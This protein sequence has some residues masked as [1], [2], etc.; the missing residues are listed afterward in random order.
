MAVDD[1]EAARANPG[2]DMHVLPAV[3]EA[4]EKRVSRGLWK[5]LARVAGKIPFA[6]DAAAAYF[7]AV[8]T[9]TPI[10]VRGAL[11]AAL[12]Y[13]II[14]IDMIPDFLAG[15]GYTDDA[16]V[17]AMALALVS[18][19]VKPGHRDAARRALD[20]NIKPSPSPS[21]PPEH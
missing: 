6:E 3:V 5:K 9:E 14:P 18:G 21:P 19:Y 13:F 8:D 2:L 4:N 11:L 16:S 15:L 1:N 7:C 12:V 10:H 17:L 20:M